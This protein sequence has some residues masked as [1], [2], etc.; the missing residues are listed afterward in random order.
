MECCTRAAK[1]SFLPRRHAAR[2]QAVVRRPFMVNR[3]TF[4][5]SRVAFPTSREF[6]SQS[7][8]VKA[9]CGKQIAMRMLA[10]RFLL[11]SGDFCKRSSMY[12][13]NSW[14]LPNSQDCKP[15]VFQLSPQQA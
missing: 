5:A 1:K 9:W 2:E 10:P 3:R 4:G 8:F 7:R 13:I 14:C 12:F 6:P 11:A 15:T